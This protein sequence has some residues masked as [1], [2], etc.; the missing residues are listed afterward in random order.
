MLRFLCCVS[1]GEVCALR[2]DCGAGG[3]LMS[4]MLRMG[5][6]R[7]EL[8]MPLVVPAMEPCR[9]GA[10]SSDISNILRTGDLGVR[11]GEE[12]L[13]P[14]PAE[15]AEPR[16]TRVGWVVPSSSARTLFLSSSSAASIDIIGFAIVKFSLRLETSLRFRLLDLEPTL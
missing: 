3:P 15:L 16:C 11:N 1:V 8:E 9:G 5:A 7:G 13:P 4:S 2:V 14:E 6:D 12:V 10:G